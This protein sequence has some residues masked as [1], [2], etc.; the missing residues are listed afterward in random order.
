MLQAARQAVHSHSDMQVTLRDMTCL[1]GRCDTQVCMC[2]RHV[3]F[4]STGS[5]FKVCVHAAVSVIEVFDGLLL[6]RYV[7]LQIGLGWPHEEFA[8]EATAALDAG[9]ID[10]AAVQRLAQA[11]Q[12]QMPGA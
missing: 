11:R 2:L 3:G 10:K 4:R 9:L 8:S 6:K 1:C 12:A 5:T 7:I